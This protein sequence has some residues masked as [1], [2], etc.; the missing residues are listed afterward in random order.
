MSVIQGILLGIL[1]GLAEFLPI[2]SSGHLLIVRNLFGFNDTSGTYLIFD[3]LL[4]VGT[5]FVVLVVFWKDWLSILKNPFRSKTLLLLFVASLPAL[6][7]VIL[8]GDLL[9]LFETGAFLGVSFVITGILL[10]I[11]QKS[12]EKFK[13]SSKTQVGFK[14]SIIMGISQILGLLPGISRSGSTIFGGIVS[15][16]DKKT[17]A[18][19]SFMMSAPAIFGSLIYEGKNALENN[20]FAQIEIIPT[21]LGMISATIFGYIAIKFMLDLIAKISLKWFAFYAIALGLIVIILQIT[22]AFGFIPMPKLIAN[23]HPAQLLV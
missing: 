9:D 2:S 10:L 22:G 4:H 21:L 5:L 19:F 6:I 12:S 13:N 11:S 15:G 8:F 7:A 14:N 16:L 1:Q 18:K 17:A 3:I 23:M 20:Y